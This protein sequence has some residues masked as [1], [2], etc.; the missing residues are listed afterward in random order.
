MTDPA[1]ASSRTTRLLAHV[2]AHRGPLF[3]AWLFPILAILTATLFLGGNLGK[4]TDDYAINLR[5]P[6]TNAIPSP[7]NPLELYPFFW[8][9]LHNTLCFTVGTLFPDANRSVHIAVAFFHAL[10]CLG[11][12]LLL[13]EMTRTRLA[14]ALAAL[15][16]AIYPLHGEVAFWFCTTSTAI[17]T[18]IFFAAALVAVRYAR[19]E[20]SS[21]RLLLLVFALFFLIT[22]FYEQSAAPAAALPFIILG[23]SRR[24]L[25]W[26]TR[27]TRAVAAT[28]AAGLACI[29]YVVLLISTAPDYARGSTGSFIK[30]NQ[31]ASRFHEF[32]PSF[33][34]V[35]FGDRANQLVRGSLILGWKTL[36]SPLGLVAASTLL[37][38]AILWLVWATRRGGLRSELIPSPHTPPHFGWLFIAGIATFFAAWLPI[39]VIDHQIVELRNTYVPLIG[40][41]MILAAILDAL[42]SLR[43]AIISHYPVAIRFST[44]LVGIG[45]T[46]LGI[47]SLIGYQSFLQARWKLDQVQ[48]AQLKQLVPN[49][50]P[51]TI[52]VPMRESAIASHTG[53]FLFDRTRIGVFETEWSAH[54]V[55]AFAYRRND[56]SATYYNFWLPP[57]RI[58]LDGPGPDGIR[59]NHPYAKHIA[60]L[61]PKDPEGKPRIPWDNII[62]FV[63]DQRAQSGHIKLVRRI[64]AESTDHRDIVIAPPL[65]QSAISAATASGIEC[66]TV[67]YRFPMPTASPPDLIPIDFWEYSQG[68]PAEFLTVHPWNIEHKATWLAIDGGPRASM[69]VQ[70]PPLDRPENLLLRATIAD[71]DLDPARNPV[72]YTQELVVTMASRPTDILAVLRLD[73]VAIR[74]EKRWLPLIVTIPVRPPPAGD[75]I[76]IS[77]RVTNDPPTRTDPKD[78]SP[79]PTGAK[80]STLPVWVTHGFEQAITAQQSRIEGAPI[81]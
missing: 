75:R 23:L 36:H 50:P 1:P 13:R 45:A 60:R 52:F 3:A 44:A 41:A 8:R 42:L 6:V 14:P 26:P 27:L 53:H 28:M 63:T 20:R 49:P 68:K 69:S 51:G 62:P 65:V 29:A 48:I 34:F 32:F 66:P 9:P 71:Y 70:M 2:R 35:M 76:V 78:T 5:D 47:A 79:I 64:D 37:A 80:V 43:P 18:A 21:L 38:G 24:S 22:C 55:V 57:P 59:W 30:A 33:F 11:L 54:F 58:P 46:A 81:P 73:P 72:V 4:N 12:F 10:S 40:M 7:F 25:G 17:G 39:F 31:F 77:L 56:I 67:T 19:S 74:A 61:F 15:L 16:F